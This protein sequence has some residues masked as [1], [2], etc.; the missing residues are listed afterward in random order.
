MRPVLCWLQVATGLWCWFAVGRAPSPIQGV[1]VCARNKPA[2][3]HCPATR[4]MLWHARRRRVGGVAKWSRARER[5]G[6]EAGA[7]FSG[8]NVARL[9]TS[10][11]SRGKKTQ[12][13]YRNAALLPGFIF[14]HR[15]GLVA[16]HRQNV[17]HYHLATDTQTQH[18]MARTKQTARKSTGGKAPRK[19]LATKVRSMI[20]MVTLRE[21]QQRQ[22]GG[23]EAAR[24]ERE[25][26]QREGTIPRSLFLWG[27]SN[28][29]PFVPHLRA[30]TGPLRALM[31]APEPSYVLPR[32]LAK[33]EPR[34]QRRLRERLLPRRKKGGGK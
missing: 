34:P 26:D 16:S 23:G 2:C 17:Y 33:A 12:R 22:R 7:A 13:E 1:C 8:M 11:R 4:T 18:N 31:R 9:G 28:T 14:K 20:K 25:T 5:A 19:Q 21:E 6:R 24:R 27:S 29:L 32:S 30:S 3:S 15:P 10:P